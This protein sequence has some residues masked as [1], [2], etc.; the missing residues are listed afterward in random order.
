MSVNL[1]IQD[2]PRKEFT[3]HDTKPPRS[4]LGPIYVRQPPAGVP[5]SVCGM[6]FCVGLNRQSIHRALKPIDLL[7]EHIDL[8]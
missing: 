1:I 4:P 5:R 2:V 3:F 7:V 8:L 6:M